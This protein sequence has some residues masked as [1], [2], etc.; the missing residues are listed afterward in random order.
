MNVL[1]VCVPCSHLLRCRHINGTARI[2]FLK[3]KGDQVL[4][5]PKAFSFQDCKGSP[6]IG[7]IPPSD[8][9]VLMGV[10]TILKVLF[11]LASSPSP[12]KG[13]YFGRL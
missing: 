2:D 1:P 4:T 9:R 11:A 13:K 10:K 7:E 5:I 12:S 8:K 3:G 6:H